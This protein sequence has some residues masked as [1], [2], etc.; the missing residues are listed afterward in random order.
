MITDPVSFRSACPSDVSSI[1]QLIEPF[2]VQKCLLA[3]GEEELLKLVENGFVAVHDELI[4][5]FG[6]VEI[7]SPKLAEIQ[8]LAVADSHQS[9]GLGKHLVELC[10]DCAHQNGVHE[11][12]AITV[13]D[14]LF[15]DCGFDYSL[16]DQKRALFI[17]PREKQR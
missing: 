13:S 5:G 2:V 1:V 3:R 4:V 12:M 6:A 17:D 11:L 14:G 8:C 15:L 10:I 16:P 9:Q 7:Y